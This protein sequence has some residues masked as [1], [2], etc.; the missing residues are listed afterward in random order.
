MRPDNEVIQM[1]DKE[2]RLIDKDK[3]IKKIKAEIDAW[4]WSRMCMT[5]DELLKTIEEF[6]EEAELVDRWISVK[7]RLP[8]DDGEYMVW[9]KGEC[10]K[11]EFDTDSQTFGYTYD[12]YDEMYSHLVC[13]DDG[14][15]KEVTHWQFLPKPPKGE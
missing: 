4:A 12:D 7:D 9:Y 5:A 14:I 13:W 3:L 2:V 15:N 10:E 8:E 1:A 11:C 6:E